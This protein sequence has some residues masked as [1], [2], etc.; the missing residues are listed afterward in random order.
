M[1][2][3]SILLGLFIVA[4]SILGN[5]FPANARIGA[6]RS[7]IKNPASEFND[8]YVVESIPGDEKDNNLEFWKISE[9]E[10]WMEQQRADY[11]QLVDIGDKS[12]Y[13]KDANGDYFC[14]E[15]TQQDLDTLYGEWQEHL[16]LM[17]QGYRFTKPI[18]NSEGGS[19]VGV[20]GPETSPSNTAGST[21]ITMPDGSTVDFGTL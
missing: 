19:L 17:K 10:T 18:T 9:F 7:G 14:R 8:A 5:A 6:P 11:Q 12:F 1:K 16:G 3:A 15:W 20:F 21:M 13:D 4:G 2:R